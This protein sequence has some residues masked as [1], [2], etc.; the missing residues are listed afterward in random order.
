V[1]YRREAWQEN[2]TKVLTRLTAD[3]R[4]RRARGVHAASAQESR[5]VFPEFH[6]LKNLGVEA[7]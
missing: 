4:K 6:R 2:K 1:G 3:S 5:G 7:A